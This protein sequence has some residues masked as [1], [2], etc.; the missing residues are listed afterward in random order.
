M[1]VGRRGRGGG[2]VANRLS[3]GDRYGRW[4]VV[5]PSGFEVQSGARRA[6]CVVRCV[7]GYERVA[8]EYMVKGGRTTGCP[9]TKCRARF[10]AAQELGPELHALLDEKLADFMRGPDEDRS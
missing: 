8:F 5:R 3:P 4:T 9:S 2:L 7:C 10:E 1:S 6:R